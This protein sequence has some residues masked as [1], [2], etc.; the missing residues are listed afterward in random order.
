MRERDRAMTLLWCTRKSK[1]GR[2]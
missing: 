1:R 2:C